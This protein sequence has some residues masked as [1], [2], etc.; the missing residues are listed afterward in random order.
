MRSLARAVPGLLAAALALTPAWAT[1][2]VERTETDLIEEASI[3]VTGQCTHLQSQWI[4]RNLV[5]IATIYVSEV[6]KGQA[7]PVV[8]VVL[9]GGIDANRRVPVAMTVSGA[10][11]ISVQEEVLLFLMPE[12]RVA[13][14]FAIAGFSQGKYTLAT[15][16][17]GQTV[18]SQNLSDLNLQS[19]S[20]AVTQGRAK[21][22]LLGDLRQKIQET[23]SAGRQH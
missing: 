17:K 11:Q 21:T 16:A 18:A 12:A 4:D 22:L 10:P 8:T 19:R 13:N 9:P 20:G 14:G 3:I 2:V 15:E 5:T 1:T 6:L 23:L 7:G